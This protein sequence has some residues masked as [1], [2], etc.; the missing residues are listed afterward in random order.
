MD[1][2]A[3]PGPQPD[4]RPDDGLDDR[5]GL[6]DRLDPEPD[7]ALAALSAPPDDALAPPEP[8]SYLSA[9][10]DTYAYDY[11]NDAVVDDHDYLGDQWDQQ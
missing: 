8:D 10:G 3:R 6:T 1:E 11:E 5:D 4:G 9:G 7:D 2:D